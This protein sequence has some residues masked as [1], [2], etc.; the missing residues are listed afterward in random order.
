[1]VPFGIILPTEEGY[2][3]SP[4]KQ[5]ALATTVLDPGRSEKLV[6]AF[7]ASL[8]ECSRS[9]YLHSLDKIAR[10]MGSENAYGFDWSRLRNE[11]VTV[12]RAW[13]LD[14]MARTTAHK[15]MAAVCG[16]LSKAVDLEMMTGDDYLRTVRAGRIKIN[17]RPRAASGRMLQPEE[18]AALL[19]TTEKGSPG[20]AARDRAIISVFCQI[21][22]RRAEVCTLQRA[23]YVHDFTADPNTVV[24]VGRLILHGKGHKDR[25]VYIKNGTRDALAAWLEIRGDQP[26]ALF[27]QL[28]KSDEMPSTHPGA[29]LP[30]M[31]TVSMW[32][33]IRDRGRA[34]GL[35]PFSTHDLR[36]TFCSDALARGV[37]VLTVSALMGHTDPK[38]TMGYDKRGEQ[39]KMDAI[40]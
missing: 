21:G 38:I 26:G 19:K 28:L 5:T 39:R 27:T 40:A 31:S 12:I 13:L 7:I 3:M 20:R 36:R 24:L 37:D 32:S 18:I 10:K 30:G 33:M 17:E 4:K 11:H 6:S 1:M 29:G 22:A 2:P 15:H 8:N 35:D 23:D 16:V 25:T 34:A 9:T 14:T